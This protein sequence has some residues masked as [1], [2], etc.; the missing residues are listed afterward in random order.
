MTRQP[1]AAS[2]LAL[3]AATSAGA[4]TTFRVMSL[5][6][7]GGGA[8]E[9]KGIAQA[10]DDHPGRIDFVWAR[11][12]GPRVTDAAIVGEDGPRSDIMVMPW[13]SDHRAVVDRGKGLTPSS[14]APRGC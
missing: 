7:R 2:A 13:P 3:C 8:H 9:A 4:R 12:A 14:G 6:I 11:R 10:A 1:S 5:N